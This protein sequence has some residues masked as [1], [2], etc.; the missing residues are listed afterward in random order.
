MFDGVQVT[1]DVAFTS[2]KR[3]EAPVSF[4]FENFEDEMVVRKVGRYWMF[5]QGD[6]SDMGAHSFN[7]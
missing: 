1:D 3:R 4:I 5:C 2:D 6:L 7:W